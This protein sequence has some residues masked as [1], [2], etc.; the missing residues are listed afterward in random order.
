MTSL[1]YLDDTTRRL[2]SL[3]N[4]LDGLT[5]SE[6]IELLAKNLS[7]K[8]EL[9][10]GIEYLDPKPYIRT[11]ESTLK[12]LRKLSEE[13]TNRNQKLERITEVKQTDHYNNVLQLSSRANNLN[14]KFNK[15][16]LKVTQVNNSINPIGQNLTNANNLKENTH[17]LIFL[18]KCYNEFYTNHQPPIELV[19]YSPNDRKQIAASLNRLL[20]LSSKLASE[21]LENSIETHELIKTHCTQFETNLLEAFSNFY[22]AKDFQQLKELSSV[23]FQF[24]GGTNIV[25]FFIDNRSIIQELK[26]DSN[27]SDSYWR[28]LRNPDMTVALDNSTLKMFQAMTESIANEIDAIATIFQDKRNVV[29]VS[30]MNKLYVELLQARIEYLLKNASSH[31]NLSYIRMLHL[32]S[33]ELFSVTKNLKSLCI[34]RDLNISAELDKLYTGLFTPY[35]KNDSYFIIE[36]ESLDELIH[37][38][39]SNFIAKNEKIISKRHL[40]IKLQQ[41]KESQNNEMDDFEKSSESSIF[42]ESLLQQQPQHNSKNAIASD[43]TSTA[44]R[45]L[46]YSKRTRKLASISKL[47]KNVE[48]TPSL[49]DK[50]S[51][52]KSSNT[53]NGNSINNHGNGHSRNTSE[54]FGNDYQSGADTDSELSIVITEK[55]LKYA[56]ESLTRSIELVPA[57][58]NE[59]SM[60]IL[61]VLL[62]GFGHSYVFV[63]LEALYYN[64]I[65]VQQPKLNSFFGSNS[66]ELSLEFLSKLN[67]ISLQIYL[68]SLVIKKF[69]YPLILSTTIKEQLSN[70]FNSYLQDLEISLNIILNDLVYLIQK[71][72]KTILNNQSSDDFQPTASSQSIIDKTSTCDK[73]I[74]F[75]DQVFQSAYEYLDFNPSLKIDLMKK[76]VSILLLLLINHFTKFKINSNGSLILTQDIVHYISIFDNYEGLDD[77]KENFMILKD[78]TN[79]F[80]CQEEL[81]KDLCNE[82]KLVY[83]KKSLL[84]HYI[85]QRSDFNERFL[86][87]I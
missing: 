80:S 3:D 87:G 59:Y 22:V 15:L 68:L 67:L 7:L 20:T 86:L 28:D 64:G 1:S 5:V 76:I 23:L 51:R 74:K 21:E 34:S 42:A 82:G 55:I 57:K 8:S 63:G 45:L 40:Q 14:M 10:N 69:F 29:M 50:L 12:E 48:R 4:F 30:L 60:G 49:K 73:L 9:N 54:P 84:K 81:L 53:M 31:S 16:N 27:V 75:L 17:D 39:V 85:R 25:K 26:S 6:F 78:L 2:L 61:D 77:F 43:N 41:F 32:L 62:D 13:C 46:S 35:L 52:T 70:N 38:S 66:S 19:K 24:N 37:Q 44:R 83:L 56:V 72:L 71:N 18:T 47:L 58:I 33:N 65:V 36:K 79:L 11:F